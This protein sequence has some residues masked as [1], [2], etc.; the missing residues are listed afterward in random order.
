MSKKRYT[1]LSVQPSNYKQIT[2]I[3]SINAISQSIL[4]CFIFKVKYYNKAQYINNLKDQ[5]IR[6]SKNSWTTNELSLTQLK[7]FIYYTE[8]ATVGSYQLLIINGYESYQSLEFQNLCEEG[9]IITLYIP[10]H[11]SYIL[12]LLNVRCFTL[13]KQA[14]KK[15]IKSLADSYITYV[16]K[17]AFLATF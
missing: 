6:V 9:K 12:Q 13:L 16:N 5:R 4:P 10:L 7:H 1:L 17:K 14:Y 2:L 11:A 15:E 3:T 8:A